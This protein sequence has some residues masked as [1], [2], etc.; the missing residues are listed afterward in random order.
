MGCLQLHCGSCG[1]TLLAGMY[2]PGSLVRTCGSA[3]Y[4][5][6]STAVLAGAESF[7]IRR[8]QYGSM[9]EAT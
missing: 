1:Y 6:A 9:Q 5:L 8:V 2:V 7:V 4:L 3:A